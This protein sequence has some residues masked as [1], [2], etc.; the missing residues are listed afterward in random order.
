[1]NLRLDLDSITEGE[2]NPP[3]NPAI[4]QT[5]DVARITRIELGKAVGFDSA[6]SHRNPDSVRSGMET[7]DLFA[8]TGVEIE[9]WR[10][11]LHSRHASASP[12]RGAERVSP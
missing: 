9:P 5:V 7:F 11:A 12:D 10:N 6:T 3:K 8:E 1:M 2:D 4:F